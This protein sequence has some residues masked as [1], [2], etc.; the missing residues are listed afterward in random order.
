MR[1]LW[2]L[3]DGRSGVSHRAWSP[4]YTPWTGDHFHVSHLSDVGLTMRTSFL[5]QEVK[6]AGKKRE[7]L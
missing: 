5:T 4:V 6:R 3:L 7:K 1:L 2:Q